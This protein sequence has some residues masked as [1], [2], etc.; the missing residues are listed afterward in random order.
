M[1]RAPNL[2]AHCGS[3]QISL[4]SNPESIGRNSPRPA[5]GRTI[6]PPLC[7]LPFP[8]LLSRSCLQEIVMRHGMPLAI[9]WLLVLAGFLSAQERIPL[10]SPDSASAEAL[11]P[12][13]PTPVSPTSP[14]KPTLR[15][16]C[17]LRLLRK[18]RGLRLFIH[19]R[20]LIPH[21]GPRRGLPTQSPGYDGAQPRINDACFWLGV[22]GLLWWTKNQVRPSRLLTTGPGLPG[23][24]PGN[25][26]MPGTTSLGGPLNFRCGWRYR[27]LCRRLCSRS[28]AFSAWMAAC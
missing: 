18:L 10:P 4:Q 8:S 17:M 24:Q 11:P 20:T 25:L 12:P 13:T 21:Y 28:I 14:P 22:E 9:P 2:R 7:T 1:A 26:G 3:K 6:L 27:R 15:L 23:S 16:R 5:R 19:Y